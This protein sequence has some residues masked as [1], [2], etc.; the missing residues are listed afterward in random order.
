MAKV[1]IT[2]AKLPAHEDLIEAHINKARYPEG[3]GPCSLWELGQEFVIE[4]WPAKPD[5]FPC[6]WAWTDIQR[7]VAMVMFGGNPPWMAK[8]GSAITCCSD[9]FRPVSFLVERIED[10]T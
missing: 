9:G 5:D 7:D 1:R 8:Q 2:V 4:D 6:D 10:A 3:F